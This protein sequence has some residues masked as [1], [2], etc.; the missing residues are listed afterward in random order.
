MQQSQQSMGISD[1]FKPASEEKE[2]DQE[3]FSSLNGPYVYEKGTLK[4]EITQ[5]EIKR[6]SNEL[7]EIRMD[8]EYYQIEV[9]F[10]V[11]MSMH[12]YERGNLYLQSDFS[13]YKHSVKP[14]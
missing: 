13:S 10:E 14:L 12:N 1:V 11:A 5:V 2:A 6:E 9:I 4:Q 7:A 3:N 8:N